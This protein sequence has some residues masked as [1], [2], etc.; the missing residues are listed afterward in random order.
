M[1]VVVFSQ[2]CINYQPLKFSHFEGSMIPSDKIDHLMITDKEKDIFQSF[3]F[4]AQPSRNV[5]LKKLFLKF[6]IKE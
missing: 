6:T 2:T 4:R 3:M 1:Q 5:I